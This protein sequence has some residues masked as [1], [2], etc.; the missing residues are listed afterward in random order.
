L[1]HADLRAFFQKKGLKPARLNRPNFRKLRKEIDSGFPVLISMDT[2]HW[3]VVC[4][5]GKDC[6]YVMDPSI[7]R[8]LWVYHGLKRFRQRWDCWAMAIRA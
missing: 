5:Y 8:S 1:D 7:V 4:G 2:D 6:F 3:A